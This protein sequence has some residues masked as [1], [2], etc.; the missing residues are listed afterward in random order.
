[1]AVGIN[2]LSTLLNAITEAR[3][4]LKITRRALECLGFLNDSAHKDRAL[5]KFNVTVEVWGINEWT[6]SPA[7]SR[8]VAQTVNA[9]PASI[10]EAAEAHF[11]AKV[12][13]A[14]RECLV[15]MAELAAEGE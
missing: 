6:S 5:S 10:F 15:A 2:D 12:Q 7:L 11:L 8:F 3:E 13:S 9:A 4:A 14:K 1:M